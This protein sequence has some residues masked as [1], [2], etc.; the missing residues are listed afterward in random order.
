M[1]IAVLSNVNMNGTIHIL[2]REA[3]VYDVEG[4]GNEIGIL[5]NPNSSIYEY[6][7][8]M[9]FIIEDLQE[10]TGHKTDIQETAVAIS[11]WFSDLKGAIRPEITYYVSDAFC[12]GVEFSVLVDSSVKA[13]L[14][15]EWLKH[16]KELVALK[17]NVRIFPYK[18]LIENNGADASFSMKMW[19]MGKI[20]HSSVMQQLLAKTI[21]EKVNLERSTPK[22]VLLLDLDNTLWGGLAGEH[23]ITPIVL[24][25]D[26]SDFADEKTGSNLRHC[27]QK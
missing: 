21:L 19:Y 20:L 5:L 4:Y 11:Q 13:E 2:R 27:F 1:K 22:K 3:E 8:D 10:L 9:I 25:E 18:Q 17:S 7:P 14:E 26:H 24:S 12:Y 16:L 23:D 6:S 15:N